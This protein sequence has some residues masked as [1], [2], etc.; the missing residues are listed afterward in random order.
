MSKAKHLEKDVVNINEMGENNIK[1]DK[2]MK[3]V[4]NWVINK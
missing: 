3:I 1:W 2:R 4:N